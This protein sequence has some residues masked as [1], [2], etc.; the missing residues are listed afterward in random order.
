M[1]CTYTA[2]GF[3]F[4]PTE[5]KPS[6]S[7]YSGFFVI[8]A[9]ISPMRQKRLQGFTGAFPAICHIPAHAIQ[10]IHKPRIYSLRH[11]G[12]HTIKRNT[13][14]AYQIP[15]PRRTLCSST[16][17]PY[18]NKVYKSAPPCYGSMPDSAAYRRPCR[19]GVPAEGSARRRLDATNAR[20]LAIW[21]RS[22]VRA[23]RVSLTPSTRR[24]SPAAGAGR[25]A[26]EP[27]TACAVPLSGLRP[28]ANKGNNSRSVP[29]GIV[30]TASGIVVANSRS[31]S[32]KIVAK[33][34]DDKLLKVLYIVY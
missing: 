29:A 19:P 1:S 32:N 13:S 26:A 17:P 25:A 7:V 20:R 8:H 9:I 6:A 31:F 14:S 27:L 28:I 21:H 18:Y 5:Y 4:Y 30:V 24:G 34:S 11:A 12:G 2:Q 3:Y 22:A 23:W 10:R 33:S 16:Q 15:A